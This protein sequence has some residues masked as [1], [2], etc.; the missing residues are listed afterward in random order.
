MRKRIKLAILVLFGKIRF[1][2]RTVSFED[3]YNKV[4][5]MGKK[6]HGN[7]AYCSF[8]VS[9]TPGSGIEYAM[10][11]SLPYSKHVRDNNLER[12][13]EKFKEFLKEEKPLDKKEPD[14]VT[15]EL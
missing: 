14:A 1:E 3:T 5:E 13:F 15:I 4:T 11:S 6:Y 8:S 10:Y 9:K 2:Q 12:C 7:K